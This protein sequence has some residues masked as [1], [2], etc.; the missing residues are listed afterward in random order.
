VGPTIARL[1]N[2][3]LATRL[4]NVLDEHSI[5]DPAQA[6]FLPGRSIHDTLDDFIQCL[7]SSQSLPDKTDLAL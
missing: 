2:K 5:L 7:T 1:V 6:A 3:I 4:D